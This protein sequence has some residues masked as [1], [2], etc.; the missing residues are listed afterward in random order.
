MKY[1][2]AD[3]DYILIRAKLPNGHWGNVSLAKLSDEQFINWAE[4]RFDIKIKNSP[5]MVNKSWTSQDKI[6]LLNYIS[7]NM[8]G[9]PCVAMFKRK[10]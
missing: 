5:K 6:D 10:I 9:K 3:L 1:V 8:W 7:K 2:K 4:K